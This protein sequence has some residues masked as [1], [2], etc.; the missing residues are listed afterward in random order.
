MHEDTPILHT[1]FIVH[2]GFAAGA[3]ADALLQLTS[4]TRQP[5]AKQKSA[6]EWPQG[7]NLRTSYLT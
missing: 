4:P 5:H 3:A 6:H 2:V 1:T 7:H